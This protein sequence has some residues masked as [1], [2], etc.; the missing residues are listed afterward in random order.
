MN[1]L[2]AG[3]APRGT[4]R[5]QTEEPMRL[6]EDEGGPT[7]TPQG[8]PGLE[9]AMLAELRAALLG[10]VRGRLP[11]E[12]DAEDV[13]QD[14]LERLARRGSEDLED[15]RAFVWRSA[16]NAITDHHRRRASRGRTAEAL[17]WQPSDDGPQDVDRAFLAACME[18]FVHRL[19]E[20]YRQA[21]MLTDLGGISQSQA[22]RELGLSPSGMKSRVQRGRALL[23]ADLLACCSVAVDVRGRATEATPREPGCGC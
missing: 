21:L 10:W 22:A 11:S 20:P 7:G 12:A 16:R 23:R 19:D 14:V 1:G 17:A 5:R 4:V 18:P 6:M 15:V 9:G 3:P 8:A 2:E 13:V